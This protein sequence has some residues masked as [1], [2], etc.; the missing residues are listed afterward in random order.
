MHGRRIIWP[1]RNSITVETFTITPPGDEEVLIET[2]FTVISP[3]T[4][5]SYLQGKDNTAKTFP[6]RPGYSGSGRIIAIGAAVEGFAVG[7]RVVMDH[8][9]HTSHA[10]CSLHGWRGQGITT[11]GDDRIASEAAAFI[12]IASMA[13]QGVR[14]TRLE[15]GESAM[16]AGL[17][18]LGLF[19]LRFACLSGAFPVLGVDFNQQRRQL[20][21]QFGADAAISPEPDS[22]DQEARNLI[23][24]DGFDVIVEASGSASALTQML[25][26]LAL[27]GRFS[28]LGC[29]RGLAN[30]L[31]IYWDVHKKGATIIGAHNYIRPERDSHPGYWTSKD[32]F[33]TLLALLRA[34]RLDV[35]QLIS[36]IVPPTAGPEI[37]RRFLAK[38]DGLLGV[39]FDWH[40]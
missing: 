36:T 9:G 11:I 13:L 2:D 3:G 23:S 24:S 5:L 33:E 25:P 29:L 20:A 12:P 19:A 31:D 4:E 17:G 34:K 27:N 1:D 6:N 22:F 28:L 26:R 30:G 15:L 18:L 21:L 40:S 38:D 35:T 32:D 7:D 8:C 37:Y 14:K 16:I 10:L 39:L